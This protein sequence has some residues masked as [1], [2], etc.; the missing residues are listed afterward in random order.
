MDTGRTVTDNCF[1]VDNPMQLTYDL[2]IATTP[3]YCHINSPFSAQ[4]QVKLYGSYP[5]PGQILVSGVFQNNSGPTINA[6]YPATNAQIAPSLGRNL[7]AGPNAT[8]TVPLIPPNTLFTERSTQ[9]DL[10][11]T[12]RLRFGQKMRLD[13]NFDVYNVLNANSIITVVSTYGPRWQQ[14]SG[15][16]AILEG[17][18]IQLGGRLSF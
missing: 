13:A 11:L 7:A 6:L 17:R 10:R 15:V 1:I 5:L 2:N 12:K 14:P 3:T 16:S 18:L 8:F 4:T 9:L